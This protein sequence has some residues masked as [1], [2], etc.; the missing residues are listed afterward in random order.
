MLKAGGLASMNKKNED[1]GGFGS[2]ES[3]AFWGAGGAPG[4]GATSGN[5]LADFLIKDMTFGFSEFS[6][7]RPGPAAL[8]RR[9]VLRL[10]LVEAESAHDVRLRTSLLAVHESVRQRQQDHELRSRPSSRPSLGAD[11]CNGLLQPPGTDWCKQAGLLGGTPGPNR[12]L[13]PQDKNNFAPRL[14]FAWDVNGNGKSAVRAGLGL[15]YL[16]ERLSPGLNVG[17]NPPFIKLTT[18][19]RVLDSSAD[20]CGCFGTTL[21][22]PAS[23]REQS[24]EDPAQLAVELLVPARDSAAHD[25]GHRLRREQGTGVAAHG[26]H[27]SGGAGDRNKN[28]VDDRLDFMRAQGGAGVGRHPAVRRVGRPPHHD[29]GTRRRID[30]PLDA[31]AGC[32]PL[33]RLTAPGVLHAVA[34]PRQR[35]AGQFVRQPVGGRVVDRL[36]EPRPRFRPREYR[37]PPRVQ[38]R[39]RAGRARPW[40]GRTT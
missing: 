34:Q 23:G 16:R 35:R 21:G 11:A 28:G 22:A 31:D 5:V 14:G 15:F 2:Y 26:R 1:V 8:A 27:Q 20:P 39:A 6:G 36:V 3:S 38:H 19:L 40:K 13:F 32:Q 12:S 10:G 18:G 4:W 17:A 29:V 24:A 37:S 7:Q 9:R 33:G 25:V 30:V